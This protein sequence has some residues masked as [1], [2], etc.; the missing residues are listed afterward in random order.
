MEWICDH[1]LQIRVIWCITYTNVV[2]TFLQVSLKI[3]QV[4]LLGTQIKE[5][6]ARW[7][8]INHNCGHNFDVFNST[9]YVNF[10]CWKCK[11]RDNFCIYKCHFSKWNHVLF[12]L[13]NLHSL[14]QKLSSMW[15]QILHRITLLE[16]MHSTMKK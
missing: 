8:S 6:G 7:T 1:K 4:K 15:S 14:S 11:F 3:K 5:N 10:E 13:A 12:F 16:K 9:M 2:L